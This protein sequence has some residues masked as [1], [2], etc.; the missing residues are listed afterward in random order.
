[1]MWIRAKKLGITAMLLLLVAT[2]AYGQQDNTVASL[3]RLKGKVEVIQ[4]RAGRTVQGRRGLLLNTGDTV[5]TYAKSN[6]TIKFRDGSEIRLFPDTQ[7]LIKAASESKAKD[8]SFLYR[9]T[10]KAGGIWGKFVP[11]RQVATIGTPTATIGIK[12]TA[13]RIVERDNTARVALTE[14]L[15]EVENDRSKV[16]LTPG[17]RLTD[18]R[19]GDELANKVVD[20]SYKL[21]LKSEKRELT[22]EAGR[23]EEVFLTIQA[24]DLKTGGEVARTGVLYLR[25]DYDKITYPPTA[26]LNQRGF[27]RVPL[28]FAPPEASDNR[29]NGNVYVWALIDQEDADD[30]GEGRILFK[31]PVR[32]GRDRI[33][34][35]ADSGAAKRK[36]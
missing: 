15:V 21:D 7:F 27:A 32:Q 2:V 5:V 10:M 8:R 23:P 12:G 14:G 1:M 18:F 22:F 6:A 17:K 4:E 31:I 30:T 11:Q 35:K 3:D 13:L 33:E 25:S 20:I 36:Q 29:F 19:R 26:E 34:V 16:E 9:L 28:V 24:V